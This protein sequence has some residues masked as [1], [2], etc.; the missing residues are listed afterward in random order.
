[1]SRN[2]FLKRNLSIK[3]CLNQ[4]FRFYHFIEFLI[5][6]KFNHCSYFDLV[7]FDEPETKLNKRMTSLPQLLTTS[8]DQ[9]I[10]KI[11]HLKKVKKF[12]NTNNM[13][14]TETVVLTLSNN[15][16]LKTNSVSNLQQ[17]LHQITF[18]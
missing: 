2:I 18:V 9:N 5:F 15:F 7:S 6:Y 8:R 16:L 1:M 11:K 10:S 3:Q 4:L 14:F 17:Y 13:L 12:G